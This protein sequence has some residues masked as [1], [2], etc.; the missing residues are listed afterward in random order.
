MATSGSAAVHLSGRFPAG[1][2]VGLYNRAG[3]FPTAASLGEEVK[4]A[5]VKDDSTVSF[6]GLPE[7]ET[8]WV[9]AEIDGELRTAA[10]TAKAQPDPKA[11]QE[12][13]AG[14]EAAQTRAEGS[15][16][17]IVTGARGTAN[18]RVRGHQQPSVPFA[19]DRVGKPTPSEEKDPFPVPH[20]RTEDTTKG[21][22]QR[23][24][25]F[26]GEATPTDPDELQPQVPQSELPKGTPQ[27]SD[28]ELGEATPVPRDEVQ[29][30]LKQE[31][32]PKGLVQR[33]ATPEGQVEPIPQA[34]SPVREKERRDSSQAKAE[35]DTPAKPAQKTSPKA[36]KETARKKTPGRATERSKK[37]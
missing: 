11:R 32:A 10:V 25:T 20:P 13:P 35:G 17:Q 27:R 8:Y 14:A 1:T 5:K 12:R 22:P 3:D 31:D 30:A 29:P 19:Y 34:A 9:A 15:T 37:S 26:T 18:T 2:R 6:D 16:R 36:A 7:G 33:S 23:S 21:T 24:D 28:T 4:T